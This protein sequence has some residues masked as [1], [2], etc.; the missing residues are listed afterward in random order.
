MV[1]LEACVFE[2]NA[3]SARVLEKNGFVREAVRKK[4]VFKL[5]EWHDEWCYA[6]F[7]SA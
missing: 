5:G 6:R 2:G 1:R 4:R 3:G 7:L